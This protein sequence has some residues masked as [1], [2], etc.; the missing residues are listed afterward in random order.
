TGSFLNHVKKYMDKYGVPDDISAL[1][2]ILDGGNIQY[3]MEAME[4]LKEMAEGLSSRERQD[5]KTKLNIIKMTHR[6]TE[7]K[8]KAKEILEAIESV[9]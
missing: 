1:L 4:K 8:E 9:G 7:L 5:I 3:A 6:S 2:L